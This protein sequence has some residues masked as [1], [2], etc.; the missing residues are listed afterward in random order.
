M[1][2]LVLGG[3]RYVGPAIVEAALAGKH[4]VTLFNRGKTNPELFPGVEKLRGDRDANELDAL[5]GRTWDA[6]IDTYVE[7]PRLVRQALD[8]V[9]PKA[10]MYLFVSSV[11]V[12]ADLSK[13][14]V[15]ETAPLQVEPLAP[16][17]R[18]KDGDL[19][20]VGAGYEN[21]GPMK[22]ACEKLVL[23]RMKEHGAVVRPHVIVGAG[24]RSD[25][26]PYWVARVARGGDVLAPAPRE[27]PVQF[28]DVRDLGAFV[29]KLAEDG[30][31]GVFNAAGTRGCD[32]F[33]ELLHGLKVVTGGD[34]RFAWAE[35]EWLA[36]HGVAPW[37]DLPLWPPTGNEGV[38]AIST[39]RA[40]AHGF[41]PRAAGETLRDVWAWE[42]TREAGHAWKSGLTAERERELVKQLRG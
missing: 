27:Q 5:K 18:S 4:T 7:K 13:P 17:A 20:D 8:V 34:A 31:G 40:R 23:E 24:D 15:D 29:V 42:R 39:A 41:A 19:G 3:T 25:R 9:A 2:L 32:T 10:G 14:G 28:V 12:Y 37:K 38:N 33:E 26:L 35:P 30:H 1:K 6:V 16:S 22:A 11:S 36:E 21:F